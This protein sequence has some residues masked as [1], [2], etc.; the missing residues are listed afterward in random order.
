[1]T[2]FARLAFTLP[3]LAGFA[4]LCAVSASAKSQWITVGASHKMRAYLVTPEGPGPF[5]AVLVLHTSGGLQGADTGFADRLSQQGYVALVPA[6][7]EAYSIS[8][9]QRRLAFTADAQPIFDDFTA[10]LDTLRHTEKIDGTRLAAVGFSNGGYFALWL[11]AAGKVRCGVAYYGALTGA[12]TDTS[13]QRFRDAF[14]SKSSPVLV[15]H[16]DADATVPVGAAHRLVEILR[17]A[18]APYEAKIFPGADHVFE[19]ALRNPADRAAAEEAW[20]LTT[21][22]LRLYLS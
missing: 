14:S 16:G 1:M 5:P 8:P 21:A 4:V 11:A 3:I 7:L 20:T 9:Q 18:H 15:L 13:L 10:A 17:T 6:F 2:A 22:F 12:G 19:R